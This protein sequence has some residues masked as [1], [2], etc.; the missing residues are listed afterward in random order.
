MFN[1]QQ[2]QQQPRSQLTLFVNDKKGTSQNP[3]LLRGIVELTTKELQWISKE[4]KA[5]RS[6]K[7]KCSIWQKVSNDGKTKFYSGPIEPDIPFQQQQPP[8]GIPD[9][10]GPDPDDITL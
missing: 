6:G 9:F 7:L 2:Q 4:L 3:P 5:G 10:G 8:D 1:N